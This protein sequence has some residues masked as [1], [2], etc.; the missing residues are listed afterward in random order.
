M[1]FSDPADVFY[2]TFVFLP[3]HAN[4]YNLCHSRQRKLKLLTG[5]RHKIAP[6]S[7]LQQPDGPESSKGGVAEQ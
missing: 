7:Y 3:H 1:Y 4:V 2:Y 5:V 6:R